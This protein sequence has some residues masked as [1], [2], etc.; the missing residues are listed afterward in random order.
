MAAKLVADGIVVNAIMLGAFPSEMNRAARDKATDYV[1]SI[2]AGRV[3]RQEDIAAA[4]VYLAS[5]ASD[6]VIGEVLTVDGGV[7]YACP[8]NM[9]EP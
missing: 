8:P 3:G 6:Y 7:T 2:P 1:G 4:A 5:H 9:V